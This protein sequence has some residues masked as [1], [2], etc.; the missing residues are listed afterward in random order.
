MTANAYTY[1]DKDRVL[2]NYNKKDANGVLVNLTREFETTR[3]AIE[4]VRV[5]NAQAHSNATMIA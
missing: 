2:V 5:L 1:F 3:E 4:F